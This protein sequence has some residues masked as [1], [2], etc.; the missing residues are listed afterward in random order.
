MSDSGDAAPLL[1]LG[2]LLMGGLITGLIVAW[3][4]LV[5]AVDRRRDQRVGELVRW[6]RSR[7]LTVQLR[8]R[9]D[10][11][12]AFGGRPFSGDG[13][14]ANP[15]RVAWL[16]I[17]VTLRRLPVLLFELRI[18]IYN[19]HNHVIQ[20]NSVA[21]VT[22]PRPVPAMEIMP[23]RATLR[24]K[25]EASIEERFYTSYEIRH[26]DPVFRSRVLTNELMT[27]LVDTRVAYP[28]AGLRFERNQVLFWK[29][30]GLTAQWADRV[31]ALLPR[32]LD[33]I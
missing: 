24:L 23:L 9:P 12:R 32:L 19:G 13:L 15:H 7:G 30:G 11:A 2:A 6:A 31:L 29:R 21:V 20:A 26:T 14:H 3:R 27:W 28:E 22:L 5:R 8:G 1:M 10:I 16:L 18:R 17:P 33:T 4:L 25:A